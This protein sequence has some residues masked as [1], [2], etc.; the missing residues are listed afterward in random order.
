MF[1]FIQII[2]LFYNLAVKKA[3]AYLAC[4]SRSRGGLYV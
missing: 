2:L 3:K 1:D 4:L